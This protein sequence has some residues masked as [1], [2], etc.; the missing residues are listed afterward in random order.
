MGKRKEAVGPRFLSSQDPKGKKVSV[1]PGVPEEPS[2][3]PPRGWSL[4]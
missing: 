4:S 1:V 2:E 3:K